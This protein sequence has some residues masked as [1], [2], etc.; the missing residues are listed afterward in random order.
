MRNKKLIIIGTFL[1]T[2]LFSSCLSETA[3][4]ETLT[5]VKTETETVAPKSESEIE[6][7]KEDFRPKFA[8]TYTIELKGVPNSEFVEVYALHE[9]GSAKWLWIETTRNGEA[10]VKTKKDGTWKASEDEITI[11]IQ[12]NTGSISETYKLKNKVLTNT[13]DAKRF[14]KRTK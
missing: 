2:I 11:D 6:I 14:L 4:D 7:V 13:E 5:N 1:T 9:N 3:K 10:D 8:G 12:G